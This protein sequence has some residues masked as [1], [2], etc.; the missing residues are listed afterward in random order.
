MIYDAKEN[1]MGAIY[2]EYGV[3]KFS[4]FYVLQTDRLKSYTFFE[5]LMPC[6]RHCKKGKKYYHLCEIT[7]AAIEFTLKA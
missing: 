5:T 6:I 1:V 4:D 2:V 7:N 3:V